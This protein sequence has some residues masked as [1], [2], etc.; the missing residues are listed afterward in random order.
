ME[1]SDRLGLFK[2]NKHVH[3]TFSLAEKRKNTAQLRNQIKNLD[4][5][6]GRDA[7][8]YRALREALV[9][10]RVNGN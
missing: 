10:L 4:S 3:K 9:E 5:P 6:Y 1:P 2:F 7:V 8:L